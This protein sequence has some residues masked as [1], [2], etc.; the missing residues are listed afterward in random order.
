MYSLDLL[1][2]NRMASNGEGTITGAYEIYEDFLTNGTPNILYITK[3]GDVLVNPN[4]QTK[5]KCYVLAL[6]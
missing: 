2:Q 6:G 5:P 4:E 3:E 1:S